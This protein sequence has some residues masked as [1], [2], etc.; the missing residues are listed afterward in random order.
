[1]MINYLFLREFVAKKG[2]IIRVIFVII[3]QDKLMLCVDYR[4]HF[5]VVVLFE[6]VDGFVLHYSKVVLPVCNFIWEL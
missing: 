4:M 5:L 1:M 6:V 2:I 3:V